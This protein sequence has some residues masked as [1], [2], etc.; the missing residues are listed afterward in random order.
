VQ[1]WAWYSLTD[2]DFNGWLFDSSSKARTVFGDHYAAY[3]AALSATVNLAPISL[4]TEPTTPFSSTPPVTFTLYAQVVNN[5]NVETSAS[6]L[7]HF[8][9]GDPGLGGVQIGLDQ[10]ISSLAGC[11]TPATVQVTW[12]DVPA[13]DH[14]AYVVVDPLDNVAES[15][16]SDN[17]LSVSVS[18]TT[19]LP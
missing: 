15:D 18:V 11:A 4:W 16:E 10:T 2:D 1:R 6:T 19:S 13:G 8:Y 7:V 5:G 17:L 12:S 3:T 14:T 9:D